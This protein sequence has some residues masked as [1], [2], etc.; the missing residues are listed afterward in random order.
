MTFTPEQ[1]AIADSINGVKELSREHNWSVDAG[2]SFTTKRM[3]M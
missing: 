2:G 3:T 1:Q